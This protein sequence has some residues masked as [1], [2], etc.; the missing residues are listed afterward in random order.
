VSSGFGPCNNVTATSANESIV[1]YGSRG[2]G[3]PA[4]F[5]T[6]IPGTGANHLQ[7]YVR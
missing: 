6:G 5:N 4:G 3:D 7:V 2:F 1:E